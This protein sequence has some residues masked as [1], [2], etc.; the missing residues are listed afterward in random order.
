VNVALSVGPTRHRHSPL[1]RRLT[2]E[3]GINV[4]RVV[5]TGP[6]GRVTRAD[7]VRA[8]ASQDG[9]Q[10]HRTQVDAARPDAQR[11]GTFAMSVVE[12]DMSR[13]VALRDHQ[14][15]DI[16]VADQRLVVTAC[17]V[18]AAVPTLRA[19]P[20]LN[21]SNDSAGRPVRREHQHI[22]IAV[23]TPDGHVMPVVKDA[24]DLSLRGLSRRIADIV[25]RASRGEL[26]SDDVAPSTFTVTDVAQL[27]VLVDVPLAVAGHVGS[28]AIGA[29]MERPMVVR[30]SDGERAVTIRPVSYLALTYD[31]GFA[32][33]T[34]AARF[35]ALVKERLEAG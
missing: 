24:A 1:I 6:G 5:G 29:V 13:V 33:R 25:G 18:A 12:V 22:G 11:P 14:S 34:E 10:A 21:A 32:D 3:A 27:G 30:R 26:T 19:C 16:D 8:A 31:T 4:D 7:V 35:L 23:D 20:N 15:A 2:R 17:V 28:L 9:G